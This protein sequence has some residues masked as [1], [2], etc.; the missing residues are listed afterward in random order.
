MAKNRFVNPGL[1]AL[2]S[3]GTELRKWPGDPGLVSDVV[4]KTSTRRRSRS[5]PLRRRG[6][7]N[8]AS[9]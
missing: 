1:D 2:K 9:T 6:K 5:N 3:W 7:N 8:D 4:E